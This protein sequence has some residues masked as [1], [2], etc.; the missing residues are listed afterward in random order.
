MYNPWTDNSAVKAW[1]RG[2]SGVEGINK[3]EKGDTCNIF[4][5]K[6]KF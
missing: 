3:K 1:G 6:G 5:Y 4:N 2:R